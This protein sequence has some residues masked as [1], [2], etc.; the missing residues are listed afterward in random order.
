M[1]FS[2]H[3]QLAADSLPVTSLPLSEIRLINDLR[4]PW[5]LVIPR[6]E[7]ASDWQDLTDGDLAAVNTEVMQ[8]A[9]ALKT[10]TNPKKM[11]I[12]ALG[13]MVPQLHIHVVARFEDDAAW[14]GPI[15]GV[16]DMQPYENTPKLLAELR[17]ALA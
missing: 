10:L 11:N 2:L 15:W 3:P 8:V 12:A 4:F 16:G 13:N 17:E 1:A 6:I 9:R 5:A 7:G 14:P